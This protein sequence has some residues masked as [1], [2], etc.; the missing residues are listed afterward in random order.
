MWQVARIFIY[1]YL[2]LRHCLFK[3]QPHTRYPLCVCDTHKSIA[4]NPL[5]ATPVK[6]NKQTDRRTN[7]DDT[8]RGKSRMLASSAERRENNQRRRRC[9][10]IQI[11]CLFSRSRTVFGSSVS[12]QSP[13]VVSRQ[14]T[15][16]S[17]IARRC[18]N[19]KFL[20]ARI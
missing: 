19:T 10:K 16:V 9:L 14:W 5:D 4:W 13:V 1:F 20:R 11:G 2:L 15:V 18:C 17:R 12:R 6:T 8:R 7:G 3:W